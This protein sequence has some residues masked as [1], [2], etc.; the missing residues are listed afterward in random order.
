MRDT[1]KGWDIVTRQLQSSGSEEFHYTR[2][3]PCRLIKYMV[4]YLPF[5]G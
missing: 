3:S 5:S 1:G 2:L 4:T